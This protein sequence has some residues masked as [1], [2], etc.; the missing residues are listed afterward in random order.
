MSTVF[1]SRARYVS[2]RPSGN[3]VTAVP[4]FSRTIL[5]V[6]GDVFWAIDVGRPY[7]SSALWLTGEPLGVPP[8]L[9]MEL[10]AWEAASDEDLDRFES[11]LE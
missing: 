9:D 7:V 2:S 10:R 8:D 5:L 1:E 4:D 6:E 3:G 11:S